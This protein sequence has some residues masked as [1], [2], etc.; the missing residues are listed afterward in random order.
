MH[1]TKS[2]MAIVSVAALAAGPAW[3]HP[4][5]VSEFAGHSHW[6]GLAALGLSAI[7]IIALVLAGRR[8]EKRN[9]SAR[10]KSAGPA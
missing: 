2:A 6:L 3:A 4:V 9:Q 5:H 8:R 10:D 7:G 1:Q